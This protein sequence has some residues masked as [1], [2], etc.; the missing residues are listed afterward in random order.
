[1]VKVNHK[2]YILAVMRYGGEFLIT[3]S[4]SLLLLGLLLGLWE[5]W[6]SPLLGNVLLLIPIVYV[7]SRQ[8]VSLFLLYKY[9]ADWIQGPVV[10]VGYVTLHDL[11]F[12]KHDRARKFGRPDFSS[13]Q[14]Y[15]LNVV[16]AENF[17]RWLGK[18]HWK[19]I[20]E[21]TEAD[22]HFE[23]GSDALAPIPPANEFAQPLASLKRMGKSI[24]PV[25]LEVPR[26]A[27]DMVR[28]GDLI[29]LTYAH[30]TFQ[31]YQVEVMLSVM[32]PD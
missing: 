25:S 1:M 15:V 16:P 27:F 6:H 5:E 7:M 32:M 26:W 30:R 10:L 9:V 28:L 21:S 20:E 19:I 23:P 2:A 3:F 22:Y 29:R 11:Q 24:F 18:P 13:R 14:R 12:T 31:I 4:L 17:S 8:V